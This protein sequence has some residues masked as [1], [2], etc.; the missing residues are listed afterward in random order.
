[1]E[2]VEASKPRSLRDVEVEVPNKSMEEQ[3]EGKELVRFEDVMNAVSCAVD[4]LEAL[5]L[6][7]NVSEPSRNESYLFHL[8]QGYTHKCKH[9]E[10]SSKS[11]ETKYS[12]ES[13]T[14]I[15]RVSPE[16]EYFYQSGGSDSVGCIGDV[17]ILLSL[18]LK[19]VV[20]CLDV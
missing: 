3:D 9:P 18:D 13:Q 8:I 19:G 16:F 6:N 2:V 11:S 14:S 7:C 12:S 15:S 10:F 1:M 17:I 20:Q 4:V 5:R